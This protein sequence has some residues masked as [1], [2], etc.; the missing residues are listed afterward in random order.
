MTR[1]R[2]GWWWLPFGPMPPDDGDWRLLPGSIHCERGFVLERRDEGFWMAV[3]YL[4]PDGGF[5]AWSTYG[6]SCGYD[7]AV[8]ELVVAA[9]RGEHGA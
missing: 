1:R 3:A 4:N 6:A 8:I 2:Y 7:R 5:W 9:L